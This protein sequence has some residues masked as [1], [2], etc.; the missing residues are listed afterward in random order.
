M[1]LAFWC[2]IEAWLVQELTLMSPQAQRSFDPYLDRGLRFAFSLL[3]FAA[4]IAFLPVPFLVLWFAGSA[5]CYLVVLTYY[6]ASRQPLSLLVVRRRAEHAPLAAITLSHARSSH[7]LL[8]ASLVFKGLFLF[9]LTSPRPTLAAGSICLALY[10][11]LLLVVNRRYRPLA[12]IAGWETV[13]GLGAVYGYLPAWWAEWRWIDSPALL[14]RAL[15]RAAE[16]TDRLTP[17]ET[18][19]PIA[20]CM[21]FLQVERLDWAILD[22]Q[23]RG[24]DV[25]PQLNAFARRAMRYAVRPDR[26]I[27]SADADFIMLTGNAPSAD[28]PTCKIPG[29][30]YHD[31]IVH[32]MTELGFGSTVMHGASGDLFGRRTAYS[33]VGFERLFFREEFEALGPTPLAGW[34]VP[35]DDLLQ[36]AAMD[37]TARNGR[38]FQLAITA[39][40]QPLFHN[41]DRGLA[42][43]FP[44]SAQQSEQ[45]FDVMHYVDSAIGRYLQALPAETTVVLYGSR[46][47]GVEHRGV[48]YRSRPADGPGLVPFLVL[49]TGRDLSLLQRTGDSARQGEFTLQDAARWIHASL[50][51]QRTG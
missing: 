46:T 49:E 45:Y 42:R 2:A 16:G 19:A 18:P 40:S 22:F 21:V 32:R 48:G 26:C 4:L 15:A 34:S 24:Q 1:L 17:V 5:L 50:A 36:F 27:G 12:R 8:L 13:G 51:L 9:G 11:A 29:Y 10:L 38:Q 33:Q 6:D 14:E 47:S 7:L 30:P 31:T 43:F 44:G 37:F 35:D 25:T 23:I 20:N 28:L 3:A 39:T 41:Y